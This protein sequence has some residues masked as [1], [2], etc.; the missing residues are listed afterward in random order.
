MSYP[1][2]TLEEMQSF[3]VAFWKALFPRSNVGTRFSYHW[4]RLRAYA[5][6]IT[7]VHA[8]VKSAQDDVMPDR[9]TGSFLTRWGKIFGVT[10]K[11][12]TPARGE[13]ALRCYGTVGSAVAVGDQLVDPSTGLVYQV[14]EIGTVPVGG[15]YIDVDCEAVSTG[16]AT[17]LSAGVQLTF[18]APPPGIASVALLVADLDE[19]GFDEEQEGAYSARVNSELAK[20]RSGGNQDDFVKWALEVAGVAYAFCY[21]NRAGVGTV[22]IAALHIGS[23]S[24]RALDSTERATLLAYIAAKSPSQIGGDGGGL[25]VL[26]TLPDEQDVEITYTPNGDAAYEV[27]WSDE[28]APV[29]L[30][31]TPAT[32]LV[33]LAADRPGSMLAGHRFIVRGVASVQD[34]RVFTIE[35]LHADDDKF[36]V[37]ETPV[38]DFAAT[39]VVYAGGP[40]TAMIRDAIVAHMNGEIVYAD[41]GAPLPASVAESQKRSVGLKVL[42]DGIGTSNPDGQY[43]TWNGALLTSVLDKIATYPTGVRKAAC[44]TPAADYEPTDPTFPNDDA[45]YYVAPGAVLIR[46][47]W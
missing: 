17:R 1:V 47:A 9:S 3:L 43:G 14:D 8:H 44:V 10:K 28:T 31:Y 41:K 21:P 36:Y 39:D 2:P 18:V 23:G 42:A 40:L 30:A 33:Q 29:I 25:R 37:K 24:A 45:V 22:D 32:R 34:G 19:D 11:T 26:E 5:G 16:A 6:G 46:R 4:K 15:T 27:D 12:A 7:D 13:N 20:A 38:V 35:A